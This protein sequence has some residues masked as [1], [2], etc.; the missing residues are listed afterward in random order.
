MGR[1]PT[2]TSRQ[3]PEVVKPFAPS[4]YEAGYLGRQIAGAGADIA[5][6]AVRLNN[7]WM[8]IDRQRKA[9][10]RALAVERTMI[11]FTESAESMTT[12][13]RKG[14]DP[15]TYY[16]SWGKLFREK[17]RETLSGIED[18]DERNLTERAIN[19]M[20]LRE[21]PV[22]KDW[23]FKLSTSVGKA[24]LDRILFYKAKE[25]AK[26]LT[27]ADKARIR[28]EM[29]GLIGL[30][31]RNG[32][33]WPH[34]AE[35][36]MKRANMLVQEAEIRRGLVDDPEGTLKSIQKGD[37]DH[38]PEERL[39]VWEVKAERAVEKLKNKLDRTAVDRSV[40]ILKNE[41]GGDYDSMFK[42]LRDTGWTKAMGLNTEQKRKVEIAL[43]AERQLSEQA[44]VKIW[45]ETFKRGFKMLNEGRLTLSQVSAWV[46]TDELD[47]ATARYF[48]NEIEQASTRGDPKTDFAVLDRA[49][50]MI[51]RL[52]PVEKIR[53][54]VAMNLGKL[55]RSDREEL[56]DKAY[57]IRTIDQ[58][59][60]MKKAREVLK[61]GI[62]GA[63]ALKV[64]EY[65]ERVMKNYM[66]A[67][68]VVEN[69]VTKEREAGKFPGAND[70]VKWARD[71]MP[72]F[73]MTFEEF[74]EL[75][76]QKERTRERVI[77]AGG[78]EKGRE[79]MKGDYVYDPA[80]DTFKK[81]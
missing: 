68:K 27:E 6:A 52:E 24:D 49:L 45:E 62:V 10:D 19:H 47:A 1:V 80:T 14:A 57:A 2:I 75:K 9:V 29:G 11:K 53:N 34:E 25:H 76:G 81:R 72:S 12:E 35:A 64:P 33:L 65:G 48:R 70:V 26:A 41:Y 18:V 20:M 51:Y 63:G 50:S 79:K 16:R 59:Q 13:L 8:A 17:A 77:E 22:Q 69:K 60:G 31:E 43:N 28:D 5:E 36:E 56:M 3:L 67:Q 73:I 15:R 32:V 58:A 78:G 4:P 55:S 46:D 66:D 23:E 44:R 61:Q 21:I 39:S 71:I 54:F 30:M 74:M 38:I 40:E 7:K 37:F 42:R